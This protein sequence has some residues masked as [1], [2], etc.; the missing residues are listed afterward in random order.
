MLYS[1][2][3]FANYRLADARFFKFGRYRLNFR[4][5]YSGKHHAVKFPILLIRGVKA[6]LFQFAK[7]FNRITGN[8]EGTDLQPV[9]FVR[10]GSYGG[11]QFY[12]QT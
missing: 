10:R 3:L 4:A 11:N 12:P 1:L 2:I 8:F 6:N 7:H 9:F 5:A